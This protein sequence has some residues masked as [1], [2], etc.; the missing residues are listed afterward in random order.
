MDLRD[1]KIEKIRRLLGILELVASNSSCMQLKVSCIII[2]DHLSIVSTGYNGTP[3]GAINCCDNIAKMGKHYSW[4]EVHAEINALALCQAA[5]FISQERVMLVKNMPCQSCSQAIVAH[6]HK[7]GLSKIYYLNDYEDD[8][9][10]NHQHEL[11]EMAD[12][13]LIKLDLEKL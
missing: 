1:F 3:S 11:F 10:G 9:F 12:M 13:E 2:D 6:K 5:S 4:D 8:K 7:L